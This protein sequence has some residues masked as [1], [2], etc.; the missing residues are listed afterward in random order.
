MQHAFE[1]QPRI[2]PI[3]Q[4]RVIEKMNS[5]GAEFGFVLDENGRPKREEG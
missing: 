1:S 4:Q 2:R 5:F 3:P